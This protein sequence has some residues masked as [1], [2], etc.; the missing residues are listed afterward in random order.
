MKAPARGC[1]GGPA[2]ALIARCGSLGA[3]GR[4]AAAAACIAAT[5]LLAAALLLANDG[6]GGRSGRDPSQSRA[7]AAAGGHTAGGPSPAGPAAAAASVVVR[8]GG[9]PAQR[10]LRAAT[11]A[12]VR[13]G[14]GGGDADGDAD[15]LELPPDGAPSRAAP[16]GLRRLR[17]CAAAQRAQRAARAGGRGGGIFAAADPSPSA[18]L[19]SVMVA[20]ILR[21]ASSFRSGRDGAPRNI[22]SHL[23]FI[24][25][26]EYPPCL[27]S[28]ALLASDEASLNATAAAAAAAVARGAVARATV[29]LRRVAT[30]TEGRD[31]HAVQLQLRRRRALAAARNF[32]LSVALRDEGGVLWLDADIAEAR[33]GLL[34]DMAASGRDVLTPAVRIFDGTIYDCNVWAGPSAWQPNCTEQQQLAAAGTDPDKMPEPLRTAFVNRWTFGSATH[35]EE[36]RGRGAVVQVDSVGAGWLYVR[37]E[38]HRDGALF[39]TEPV[40]GAGWD[41]PGYDGQESEGLCWVAKWLGYRCWLLTEEDVTHAH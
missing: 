40:I 38:V 28:L 10:W 37:S 15:A 8:G 6:A 33:P 9:E 1:A 35:A 21:D 19:P 14:W 7:A 29:V 23:N 26:F 25:G 4:L 16:P 30:G 2:A 13:I 31:R 5:A 36:L 18:A 11:H 24:A 17:A 27:L 20:T 32:L 22:T 39:T 41:H 3:R 34:R 12:T